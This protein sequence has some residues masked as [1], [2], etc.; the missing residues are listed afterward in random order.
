[1]TKPSA[2]K[3]FASTC[4]QC[5]QQYATATSLEDRA[6]W[7][8]QLVALQ[9]TARLMR[10]EIARLSGDLAN[11]KRAAAYL[12]HKESGQARISQLQV[13]CCWPAIAA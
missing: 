12:H 11:R 4:L 5:Q 10:A 7:E 3:Q 9:D 2:F 13:W 8:T 1:M 6:L